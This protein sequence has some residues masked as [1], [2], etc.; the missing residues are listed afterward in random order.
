VTVSVDVTLPHRRRIAVLVEALR[1]THLRRARR[2]LRIRVVA[3]VTAT[4]RVW[5]P[6]TVRIRTIVQTR[7]RAL[8][9]RRAAFARKWTRDA[10]KQVR[11]GRAGHAAFGAVAVHAVV[12]LTRRRARDRSV[13]VHGRRVVPTSRDERDPEDH[14]KN[15]R[16]HLDSPHPRRSYAHRRER[17]FSFSS[18]K[19]R[20]ERAKQRRIFDTK[21]TIDDEF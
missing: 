20:T 12:A 14:A 5:A 11:I 13:D 9:A 8:V 15:D 3:V 10:A 18:G 7:V 17:S 2:A 16:T 1:I 4:T 21:R 19:D 6:V